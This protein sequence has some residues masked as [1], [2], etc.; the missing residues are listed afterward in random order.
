MT[1]GWEQASSVVT[2]RIA[3]EMVKTFVASGGTLVDTARIY[4]GGSCEAMVNE[5]CKD[6]DVLVGTKA[7]PSQSLA[8]D[9]GLSLPGL[10][11]QFETSS[12]N[13][14][15]CFPLHE[16]YL[17]QP[18]PESDLLDSLRYVDGLIKSGKVKKLGLSN[19]NVN[20]VKRAF[21][22]CDSHG[23]TPPSVY[24]GLMNPLNRMV[25]AELL[26]FLR[27]RGCS[28]VAYNPLAAGLLTG[29]HMEGTEVLE[30]RFKDN[31]NYLP[32]FYTEGN[33]RA[34]SRIRE[35]CEAANIS[36]VEGSYLWLLRHSAL[37]ENDGVLLGA[38]SIAQLE[39]NL[40]ACE[41]AKRE[42]LPEEVRV[43]FEEAWEV[44]KTE[45]PF[46]YWRA[47]S[48]D[49]PGGESM[50]QGEAYAVKK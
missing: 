19:Y 22:L 15:D 16:Y 28:F 40:K 21:S 1:F 39:S 10:E 26:P 12:D 7:H 6:L 2:Q 37:G 3:T 24:Q 46:K 8:S 34:L 50:D 38:S 29:K 45:N 25:E 13:L 11:K 47:F 30:G 9:S 49:M 43:A 17:H 48:R 36:M 18:D 32:R 41:R 42:V 5:A 33:F 20:E 23:L 44:T 31:Q 35:A 27:S 4:S 14:P